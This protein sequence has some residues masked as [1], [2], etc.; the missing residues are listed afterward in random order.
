MV[1]EPETVAQSQDDK[2][3]V[4]TIF[5]FLNPLA[6]G[7]L[8][9]WL[10]SQW[11]KRRDSTRE[12]TSHSDDLTTQQSLEKP[13]LSAAHQELRDALAVTE[14]AA[15]S[16]PIGPNYS[17][18]ADDRSLLPDEVRT[19]INDRDDYAEKVAELEHARLVIAEQQ[20]RLLL[21]QA[22]ARTDALT[23]LFNRRAMNDWLDHSLKRY[24]LYGEA[25][26]LMLIDID[27]F[28]LINDDLGHVEGDRV[29]QQVAEVLVASLKPQHQLARY[30][31]DEFSIVLPASDISVAQVSGM[32]FLESFAKHSF[33]IEN[34]LRQITLT[35]GIA[36]QTENLEKLELI[37]RADACLIAAKSAGKNRCC[38]F[39]HGIGLPVAALPAVI[40][41]ENR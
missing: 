29:L 19:E 10:G 25:Y 22:E 37:K 24:R 5:D 32:Q 27:D 28:K 14:W 6:C 35:I 4:L 1:V 30:G 41:V 15:S 20:Q 18:A 34:Q 7:L 38:Y 36:Q 33:G 17:S 8:G 12:F 11:Y 16:F 23:G 9:A 40:S 2:G 26:S 39:D 21:S 13:G 31:G 3:S